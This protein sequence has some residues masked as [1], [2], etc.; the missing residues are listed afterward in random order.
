M[1]MH[2]PIHTPIHMHVHVHTHTHTHIHIHIHIHVH[3]HMRTFLPGQQSLKL[4]QRLLG[5]PS[6]A[7]EQLGAKQAEARARS[8]RWRRYTASV[9]GIE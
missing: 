8:R 3:I 4:Q 5:T 7:P 1:H 6:L 2:T 9:G